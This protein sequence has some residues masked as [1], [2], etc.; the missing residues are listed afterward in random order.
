MIFAVITMLTLAAISL[1][2]YLFLKKKAVFVAAIAFSVLSIITFSYGMSRVTDVSTGS[3][4][5][6]GTISI[7]LPGMSETAVHCSWHPSIGYY[8]AIAGMILM[9]LHSIFNI[10]SAKRIE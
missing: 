10:L 1:L 2:S 8:M 3:F 7:S 4:W 9:A 5:G 6:D